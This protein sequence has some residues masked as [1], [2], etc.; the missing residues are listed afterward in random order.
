M[1]RSGTLSATFPVATLSLDTWYHLAVSSTNSTVRMYIDGALVA[2]DLAGTASAPTANVWIGSVLG[3]S[4]FFDGELDD[5]QVWNREISA[6]EIKSICDD[7]LLDW[8]KNT[9]PLIVAATSVGGAP[10]TGLG[11]PIAAHH[12][13]MMRAS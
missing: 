11:I 9:L 4:N 12:Y 5:I 10:P 1:F 2:S 13:K 7:P 8:R 3:S 6:R